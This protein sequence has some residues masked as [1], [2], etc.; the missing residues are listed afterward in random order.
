MCRCVISYNFNFAFLFLANY[1]VQIFNFLDSF[2]SRSQQ[3]KKD[4]FPKMSAEIKFSPLK[5]SDGSIFGQ[6]ELL[7]PYQKFNKLE[8]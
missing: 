6:K 7:N 3:N 8:K 1:K 5:I 4:L 2:P